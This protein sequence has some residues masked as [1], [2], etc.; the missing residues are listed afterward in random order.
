MLTTLRASPNMA[1][2]RSTERKRVCFTL[3]PSGMFTSRRTGAS[4]L[5]N[6]SWMSFR[7]SVLGTGTSALMNTNTTQ[8]GC[9]AR[10]E[11]KRLS[12]SQRFAW[13]VG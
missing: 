11:D 5:R 10:N 6:T 2:A 13:T 4:S 1:I 12:T 3:S 9:C 8:L 7:V